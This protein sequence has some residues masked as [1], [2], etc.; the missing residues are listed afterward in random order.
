MIEAK[1]LT[2]VYQMG[3]NQVHA[4][5]GVD[6]Q[7]AAGEFVALMGSSGSGKSTLLHLLGCLDTPTAGDYHLDGRDVSA[8]SRDE[9]A[10]VRNQSIGFVFQSFHLLPRLNALENVTLPLLYRGRTEKAR[11]RAAKALARVGLAERM[12]HQPVELSGGERQRVAI[13][14]ALVNDPAI[15][16]ADE[17]TGNLDSRTGAEVMEL[18]A[19]LHADG[20]TVL[21]VTHDAQVS[22]WAQRTLHVQDGRLAPIVP[23]VEAV[24]REVRR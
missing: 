23:K 6:M 3:T 2:K 22:A 19:E 13:A 24:E 9:R 12:D 11:E 8:L 20:R 17:P 5:R 21:V 14:R 18:L 7:V 10:M 1:G 15:V 4:L 16:L